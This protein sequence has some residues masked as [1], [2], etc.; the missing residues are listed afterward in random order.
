[1]CEQIS[2]IAQKNDGDIDDRSRFFAILIA[3]FASMSQV[4]LIS[5]LKFLVLANF[6]GFLT[7]VNMI[8]SNQ[9]YVLVI[10]LARFPNRTTESA[11]YWVATFCGAGVRE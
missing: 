8:G 11:P 7:L 5:K 6:K 10:L 4:I 3:H 9:Q 1:L 2:K